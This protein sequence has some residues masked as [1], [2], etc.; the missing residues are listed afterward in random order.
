MQVHL[1]QIGA[2]ENFRG[3]EEV[4]LFQGEVKGR[5]P[6]QEGQESVRTGT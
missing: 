1:H 4:V 6:V 5:M 2:A 3:M